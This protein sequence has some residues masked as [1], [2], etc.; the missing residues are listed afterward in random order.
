MPS[1][2]SEAQQFYRKRFR[3]ISRHKTALSESGVEPILQLPPA[4]RVLPE[5]HGANLLSNVLD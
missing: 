4:V 5:V 2:I 1:V 3:L